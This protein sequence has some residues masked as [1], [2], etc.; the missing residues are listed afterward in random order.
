[1]EAVFLVEY[2]LIIYFKHKSVLLK[3]VFMFKFCVS[4]NVS[5]E[6]CSY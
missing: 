4:E 6:C 2:F 5:C 1:M 3:A